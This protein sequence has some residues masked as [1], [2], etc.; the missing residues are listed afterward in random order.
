MGQIMRERIRER[1]G[2]ERCNGY[3]V[4][5]IRVYSGKMTVR[6]VVV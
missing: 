6:D 1:N 3:G 4:G 2:G 5:V